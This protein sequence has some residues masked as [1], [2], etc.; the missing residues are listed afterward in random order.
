MK[1]LTGLDA[2]AD[3]HRAMGGERADLS[4]AA[5]VPSPEKGPNLLYVSRD[6]KARRGKEVTLVEGFDPD[7]H[8]DLAL[9]TA[10]A[11][12][13]H[14]GV[15]GGWKGGMVLLQGDHRER[16]A[17]WLRDNGFTVKHKGG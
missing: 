5:D 6:K 3:L 13:A 7:Q 4:D 2:L 16:A 14:C 11:L 8:A 17:Q 9:E 10:R 15:G 1:K 12:K